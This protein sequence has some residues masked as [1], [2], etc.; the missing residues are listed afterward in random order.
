[1]SRKTAGNLIRTARLEKDYTLEITAKLVGVS[2]NY[3]AKLEK[4]ET[5]NPS[6]EVL[7]NLAKV[8]D[9]DETRLFELFEKIPP[10]TKEIF[11]T[12]PTLYREINQITT[13][14]D[15]NEK[16]KKILLEKLIHWYKKISE[17]E[18]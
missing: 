5:Q 2:I 12:N 4:G 15:L 10:E 9:L 6:D 18:D 8:L 7:S 11:N 17:A 3:I 13:R 1:M 14:S 16:Q